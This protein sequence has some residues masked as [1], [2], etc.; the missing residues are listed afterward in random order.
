MDYK[1]NKEYDSKD[2]KHYM[3]KEL[4]LSGKTIT[5]LKSRTNGIMLNGT[6]VTVRALLHDGDSLSLKTEQEDK[7]SDKIKP[8]PMML[9]IIYED[10]FYIALNKGANMPT[11]P[12]HD[13]YDDTLAN[14]LAHLY[15]ERNLPFVFRAV[16]RLDRDTSGI[17]VFAKNAT[18]ANEFSKLQQNK[19]IKKQYVAIVNGIVEGSG[20]IQGY[21]KRKE[22]SVM[23]REFSK[24]DIGDGAMFSHTD[25]QSLATTGD[26]SLLAL[27]LHTGRTHQIRVHTS[28][29]G[30]P[31]IGDGLYGTED[32][33]TRHMLHAFKMIFTHPF[34]KKQILL[35]ADIPYDMRSVMIEKGIDYDF[36]K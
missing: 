1:I 16:N 6:Q 11:H 27:L 31:I 5:K 13:H 32:G 19:L 4:R 12:S 25:Y 21:I 24:S 8:V 34:T 18:A 36:S 7:T 35:R 29:L 28:Y 14:G 30:H 20:S 23:L 17:V 26:C 3:Q 33:Y 10:D 22:N 15:R 2:V 9:D